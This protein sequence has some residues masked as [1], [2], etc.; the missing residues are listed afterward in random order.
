MAGISSRALAFG[1][2]NNYKYNGKEKQEQELADGS[3]L[4]WYD[5][6]ARMY[7]AQVGRWGV[8]DPLLEKLVAW[9]P[10]NYCINNPLSY[11]DF[12]G[13]EIVNPNDPKVIELRE[14]MQKTKVGSAIWAAMEVYRSYYVSFVSKRIIQF[15]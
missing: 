15:S 3:S 1:K 8:I 4:E 11:I 7:D 13:N 9:T 2:T 14:A 6:G 12:D 10:Y 5:Y